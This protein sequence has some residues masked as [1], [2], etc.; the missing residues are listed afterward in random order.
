MVTAEE[1]S[2]MT[3]DPEDLNK[4]DEGIFRMLTEG[5]CTPRY[6]AGEL[7]LQ[8][9]YVNQRLKRLVEH[10]HVTRVDRGLY[11]LDSDPREAAEE[12]EQSAGRGVYEQAVEDRE[13]AEPEDAQERASDITEGD[14]DLAAV[15][16]DVAEG[17]D[18]TPDRLEARKAAA[19]AV[20]EYAREQGSVSKKEAKEELYPEHPVRDQDARTWYRKN[21]RPVLNEVAEYN[22]STR[23]YELAVGE[24]GDGALDGGVYDPTEDL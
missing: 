21:V 10:G 2:D 11:E 3:L 8:Q 23:K 24:E 1:D 20:L 5:R 7:D 19:L 22:K 4:T 16:N 15:V 18:D 14:G 6:I 17:W 9:P 12:D 13:P